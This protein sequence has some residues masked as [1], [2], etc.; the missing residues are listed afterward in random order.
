MGVN[1]LL[2][3]LTAM[4]C[5]GAIAVAFLQQLEAGRLN[6]F[7]AG[8]IFTGLL[9]VGLV[10]LYFVRRS[11]P[12][13]KREHWRLRKIRRWLRKKE[14]EMNWNARRPG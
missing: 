6:G 13:G 9:V 5:T 11:P 12:P 8:A 10:A 14:R 3:G 4:C 7:Q 1:Y 2:Y